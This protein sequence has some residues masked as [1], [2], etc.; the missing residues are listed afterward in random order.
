MSSTTTVH[1]PRLRHGRAGPLALPR[2]GP[3][4]FPRLSLLLVLALL[5]WVGMQQLATPDVVPASAPATEFSAARAIEH[6]RV[7]AAE[8]R[9]VGLPGHTAT[10]EYLVEQLEALGLEPEIQITSVAVTGEGGAA[11]IGAGRVYNI[12]ARIPGTDNTGAIAID[13]HYDSGATGPGAM[14]AGSGVV[15]MLETAR[16]IVAGP[17][18]RNDVI[19]VFAD[20]EEEGMLGAAAFNQQH[21]WADD[22][23]LAINFEGAG[24][25]GPALLYATS[26]HDHWLVSEFLD[27]APYPS[28]SSL[29]TGIVDLY[30]AGRLDCD[31]GEYTDHGSAGL[32]FVVLGD[33]PVYH[34]IRDN[35]DEI[36]HGSLQQEG[37]NTLAAVRHFGNLDLSDIDERSDSVFFN[38][39]SGVVV[40]YPVY[41]AIAV[42][43][44]TTAI[45]GLLLVTG[46][47]TS[48]LTRRGLLAGSLVYLLGTLGAVII[49]VLLWAVIHTT[50]SDYQ[51]M[52]VG[53][54]QSGYFVVALAVATV[55]V[56]ATLYTLFDRRIRRDNQVA[57]ALLGG[58][59]PLWFSTLLVPSMSYLVAW[60]L[61]FATVP[62]LWSFFAGRWAE[63]PWLRMAAL[64]IAAI[65]AMVILPGTLHAMLGLVNRL[66]GLS[67]MPLLGVLM[68]FVAPLA[69]LFVPHL[70]FVAGPADSTRPR[71]WAFP[72]VV[73]LLAIALLG[74]G[75]ATSGFDVEH[76]R[77]DR[78]GY[79]LNA[80]TGEAVW[81]SYDKQLDN[82]TSQFFPEDAKAVDHETE[83][84]GTLPA[85]VAP[86]P[87]ADLSL[88]VVTVIDD[89]IDGD[90]RTLRLR[91]TSPQ[92]ARISVAN[93]DA[94]GEVVAVAVDGQSLD[95]R[96][97]DWARDGEFP[98]IYRNVPDD[99]WELT[100]S[101]RSTDPIVVEIE[102][103]KDGLPDLAGFTVDPRPADTMASPSYAYDPTTIIRSFTFE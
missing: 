99:G 21:A 44:F 23:R 91:I 75:T 82:W 65:P 103:I 96:D 10:R 30:G 54:Y 22:V 52:L 1:R 69:G 88:P 9:A 74:W 7:I 16:A 84:L 92:D 26:Q 4:L 57:G 14:D 85:F 32:G 80:D 64:A 12:L 58:L 39:W 51:V 38:V 81:V 76:P 97:T 33:T 49:A 2:G 20:G 29:M 53:N 55:A 34:T 73:G 17:A 25:D 40:H 19:L 102:D 87:I 101:V 98:V 71:R 79:E 27:A 89:A 94:P 42:A 15:T 24:G 66:E 78:I 77:P 45:I 47:R 5:A 36:D 100:L 11:G 95:L 18:L 61:L 8:P 41:G 35:P 56:V 48:R 90:M 62:M 72:G 59:L 6:L 67:G 60:P 63:K 28:A 13:A 37:A 93:V 50:N 68:L 46:L 31:L 70:H 83:L 43:A 3:L 86:A